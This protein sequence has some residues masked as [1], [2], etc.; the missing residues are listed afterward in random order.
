MKCLI[1]SDK[2]QPAPDD[3]LADLNVNL[4]RVRGGGEDERGEEAEKGEDKENNN[5]SLFNNSGE[6][7]ELPQINKSSGQ[8]HPHPAGM[9]Q[10]PVYNIPV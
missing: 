2:A 9:L 10:R 6:V 3:T 8:P 1:L 5:I 4:L 7:D